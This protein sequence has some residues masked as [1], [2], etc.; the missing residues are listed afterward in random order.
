MVVRAARR[1]PLNSTGPAVSRQV[2]AD[3]PPSRSTPFRSAG[4]ASAAAT[5]G[6]AKTS[7][8]RVGRA[9][10][11]SEKVRAPYSASSSTPLGRIEKRTRLGTGPPS[12]LRITS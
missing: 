2:T 5:D 7:N 12:R 9:T 6:R 4:M 10:A 1:S 3:G 8:W 11:P